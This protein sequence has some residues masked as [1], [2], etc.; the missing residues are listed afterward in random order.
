M[1]FILVHFGSRIAVRSVENYCRY[2]D[3]ELVIFLSSIHFFNWLFL[4]NNDYFKELNLNAHYRNSLI[5]SN[6]G[7]A[8]EE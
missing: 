4:A 5:F 6:F 2:R 1:E 7:N 8:H 3:S